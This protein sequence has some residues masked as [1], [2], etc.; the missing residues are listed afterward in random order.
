MLFATVIAAPLM[1]LTQISLHNTSSTKRQ[2]ANA[3]VGAVVPFPWALLEHGSFDA[4][5]FAMQLGARA[6][7]VQLPRTQSAPWR[8]RTAPPARLPQSAREP[9]RP[10]PHVRAS[11]FTLLL[12]PSALAPIKLFFNRLSALMLAHFRSHDVEHT[13]FPP[14]VSCLMG[15][16]CAPPSFALQHCGCH[17][18]SI[19][20]PSFPS[21]FLHPRSCGEVQRPRRPGVHGLPVGKVRSHHRRN[22]VLPVPRW[23]RL[24]RR[25]VCHTQRVHRMYVSF[26]E[27]RR[28]FAMRSLAQDH[29]LCVL[30]DPTQTSP[31]PP[32]QAP[33]ASTR[34]PTA[35]PLAF[36]APPVPSRTSSAP[37]CAR[38][39]AREPTRTWAVVSLAPRC[40]WTALRACMAWA[41]PVWTTSAGRPPPRP[42]APQRTCACSA[43]RASTRTRRARKTAWAGGCADSRLANPLA[44]LTPHAPRPV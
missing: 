40:V 16:P 31:C 21:S 22:P 34:P 19:I 35:P 28:E 23:I 33:L 11:F 38:S 26:P 20:P 44:P 32:L 5:C 24:R 37:C 12:L 41:P 8:A 42:S 1:H 27:R 14:L 43:P 25:R 10:A 36:L 4:V 39:A 30:C 7:R 13:T 9:C 18:H 2:A 29:L 17:M 15:W 6:S 3:V